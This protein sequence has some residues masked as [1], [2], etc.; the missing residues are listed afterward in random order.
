MYT[1]FGVDF[2]CIFAMIDICP[3]IQAHTEKFK[4]DYVSIRSTIIWN[5]VVTFSLQ[6]IRSVSC[7]MEPVYLQTRS[8]L[9]LTQI[10]TAT[11]DVLQ[12]RPYGKERN[13]DQFPPDF[14]RYRIVCH[15]NVSTKIRQNLNR[16]HVALINRSEF[17]QFS[18]KN[19]HRQTEGARK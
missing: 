17:G 9:G 10:Q 8:R 12:L 15:K 13:K 2:F 6:Q 11:F 19:I 4:T 14:S 3:K 7:S 1:C 5:L 18:V 16:P